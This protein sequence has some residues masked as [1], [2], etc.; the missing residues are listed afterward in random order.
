VL[1]VLY[2]H[3]AQIKE[4]CADTTYD[5]DECLI[6]GENREKMIL[7]SFAGSCDKPCQSEP[8]FGHFFWLCVCVC[9]CV[10]S[11]MLKHVQQA[12][13]EP[14]FLL[15]GRQSLLVGPFRACA[16]EIALSRYTR[17]S[18]EPTE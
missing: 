1:V 13:G 3:L 4:R 8:F 11:C 5:Y 12:G 16:D 14:Y 9:V 18:S 10:D 7:S 2:L 15:P 17:V 6:G